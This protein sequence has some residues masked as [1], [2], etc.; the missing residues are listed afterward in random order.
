[1][2][3]WAK[4]QNFWV[5]RI[6]KRIREKWMTWFKKKWGKL[7]KQKLYRCETLTQTK[8][9]SWSIPVKASL[10]QEDWEEKWENVYQQ[11]ISSWWEGVGLFPHENCHE[12]G[13]N[14]YNSKKG[15]SIEYC[16]RQVLR[17]LR[18]SNLFFQCIKF[19]FRILGSQKFHMKFL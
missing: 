1:M 9:V 10:C 19:F 14:H 17:K 7:N 15:S 3:W 12:S 11:L 18:D 6:T 2:F 16:H 4:D 8:M 5:H 13:I